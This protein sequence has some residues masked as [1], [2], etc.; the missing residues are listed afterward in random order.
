MANSAGPVEPAVS[1][2]SILFA[3]LPGSISQSFLYFKSTLTYIRNNI[4]L[5]NFAFAHKS[6]ETNKYGIWTQSSENMPSSMR[7]MR[8]FISYCTCVNFHPGICS[9][10]KPSTISNGSVNGQ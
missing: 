7:K 10:L 2:R 8:R 3:K 4:C 6:N 5:A 1:P 9:P